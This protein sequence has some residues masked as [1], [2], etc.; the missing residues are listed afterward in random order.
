LLHVEDLTRPGLHPATLQID[1]GECVAVSGASG[2]GKSLLL[3][4][5]ADLDPCDGRVRLNGE[6]R[7]GMTAPAWRRQVIYVPADSGWWATCVGDHFEDR[8]AAAGFLSRFEL[9]P[10]A[11]EWEVTRLSTGERQRLALIRAMILA[12]PVLLLDEPT[13]GLDNDATARVE[14][15]LHEHLATGAAI[16]LVTHDERQ[17]ARLSPRGYRIDGGHLAEVE[18]WGS[19]GGGRT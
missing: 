11:L 8:A 1:V 19:A 10:D 9:P 3:R 13:S 2:A 18:D 5:I 14:A 17:A 6:D 7:A 4:A 15:L 12:P 16:L